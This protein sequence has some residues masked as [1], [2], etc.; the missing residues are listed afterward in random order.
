MGSLTSAVLSVRGLPCSLNEPRLA[1]GTLTVQLGSYAEN[2]TRARL[3]S[4]HAVITASLAS[5]AWHA[6]I[7]HHGIIGMAR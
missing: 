3:P 1:S 5:L 7:M 4:W 6:G 2:H